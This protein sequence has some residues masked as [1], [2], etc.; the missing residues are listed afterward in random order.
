M[1]LEQLI[2]YFETSPAVRLLRAQFAPFILHFLFQQFKGPGRL[3]MS[4]SELSAALGDY[5]TTIHVTHAEVLRDKADQYLVTW[6]SGETRWL[7][8]SLEAGR[9]EPVYQL[10]PHT[11]EVFVYLDRAL[12]KDLGFVGTESRLR[13]VIGTLSDLVAGASRDP[14]VRLNHLRDERTRIDD[15]IDTILRDGHV[16]ARY[17]PAT[18]RE[19][20]LTAVALLKELLADFRAVEDRFKDITRQVQKRHMDGKESRGSILEF[21]LDAEDVLKK[22]DQG[23]SFYEFVRFILSPR[24]QEKLRGIITELGRIDELAEQTEGLG[25]VRRMVK[26]LIADAEKVMRTNQRL[27]ATLRR[28]LD[29]RA[30]LDRRRLTHLLNDIR[31]IAARLAEDPPRDEV[32]IEV[33][34]GVSLNAPFSRTFWT[35][36]AKFTKVDMAENEV[37]GERR[38]QLFEMLAQMHRLDWRLMREHVRE[39]TEGKEAPP[40]LGDLVRI[41]PPQ[42]GVIEL[43]GYLQIAKDDGHIVSRDKVEDIVIASEDASVRRSVTVPLVLFLSRSERTHATI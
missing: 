29:S 24:E 11:E 36:P 37:D 41:F 14:D 39:V 30:A 38:L 28:L 20:F 16:A 31:T 8:R 27:S 7:H 10:T 6:S 22:D 23:V 40:S 4:A 25:T 42:A 17:E 9:N 35:A 19:R 43:L 3:S 33:D 21:A 32:S 34:V 1:R 5:Q 18:I 13:L 12:Q 26:S 15:E 2:T